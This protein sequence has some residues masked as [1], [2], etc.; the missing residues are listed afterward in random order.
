MKSKITIILGLFLAVL[1]F[2]CDNQ[3]P[4]L[5]S[6]DLE[7]ISEDEINSL[8]FDEIGDEDAQQPICG[9]HLPN[10]RQRM[11]NH[12][13]DRDCLTV[14]SSG[15]D[16][17]KEIIIDY[18]EGCVGRHGELRTG[19]IIITMSD[20]IF[21]AGAE[22][23]IKFEDVMIGERSVEMT[24]TRINAGQNEEGNWV[25]ES[26][27][28]QIITYED[29]SSST[30]NSTGKNE[31]L[32]GFGTEDKEDDILERSFSGDV[33]TSE[34]AEYSRKTTT[35]L[36]IDRSCLYIKSGVIELNRN[37]TQVI[38]DFGEGE[39]DEWATVTKDGVSELVDLSQRGKKM[40]GFR[41]KGK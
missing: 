26:T 32:S 23:V 5:V 7:T 16:Y 39:C 17:P 22:H 40:T 28:D 36:L 33:V 9:N 41:H 8:K 21:N 38:I 10:F 11:M 27:M 12:R 4:D 20:D 15:D 30:R 18:G 31:W 13:F 34:G 14:T 25:M 24:K 19:K 2:S 37:G 35:P 6:N 1:F 3:S 29:G